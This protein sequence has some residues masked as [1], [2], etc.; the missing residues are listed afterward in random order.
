MSVLMRQSKLE[1]V[2][3]TA[4]Y[5]NIDRMQEAFV[6]FTDS[7]VQQGTETHT[8][9]PYRHWQD[10]WEAFQETDFFHKGLG[11]PQPSTELTR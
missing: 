8:A 3:D 2:V 10:L 4:L 11:I 1:G 6:A 7:I 9:V 5:E